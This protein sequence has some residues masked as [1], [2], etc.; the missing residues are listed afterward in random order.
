MSPEISPDMSIV[1]M[2][3]TVMLSAG[4]W[5]MKYGPPL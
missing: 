4:R 2:T 1:T 3:G 5:L